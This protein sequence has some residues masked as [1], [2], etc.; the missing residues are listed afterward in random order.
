MR[1]LI[2]V[3]CLAFPC[4]GC[5]DADSEARGGQISI[6]VLMPLTA[7]LLASQAPGWEAAAK[8]A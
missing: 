4:A 3:G 7:G 8:V 2:L 5:G 1:Y 6:G